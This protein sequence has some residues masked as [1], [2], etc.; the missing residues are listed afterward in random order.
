MASVENGTDHNAN[1]KSKSL[2]VSILTL[3]RQP[4]QELAAYL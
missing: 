1:H 3:M 4:S 2:D